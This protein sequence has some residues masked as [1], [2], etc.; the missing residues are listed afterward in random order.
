[1]SSSID[2]VTCEKC[3]NI[4]LREQDTRT[5][6]VTISCPTCERG[7][8]RK[9]KIKKENEV[10]FGTLEEDGRLTN[11]RLIKQ[12]DITKCPHCIMVPEHYRADGSCKCDDA[13]ERKKMIKMWGYKRGDFVGIAIK[14]KIGGS[15]RNG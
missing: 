1:M 12:S 5:C 11:V 8:Q 13:E 2:E 6:K 15:V 4:A 10:Q 3:G 9:G 14:G 7:S